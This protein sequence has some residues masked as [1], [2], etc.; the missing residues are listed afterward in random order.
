MSAIRATAGR[1][2]GVAASALLLSLAMPPAL[3]APPSDCVRAAFAAAAPAR[4]DAFAGLD[5]AALLARVDALRGD[6]DLAGAV[7][8]LA[9]AGC[10]RHGVY[11]AAP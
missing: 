9:A 4:C 1:V 2:R 3:A 5:P 8:A 6:D 7:R 10:A 11:T